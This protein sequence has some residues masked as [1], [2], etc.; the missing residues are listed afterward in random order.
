MRSIY[1]WIIGG[2]LTPEDN[3]HEW[4]RIKLFINISVTLVVIGSLVSIAALILGTHAILVPGMGNAVLATI[5]I[6]LLKF[7]KI[8]AAEIFYFSSLFILLFGNLIFNE[9]TMH[10]GSPFWVM[11]LNI[12]VTYIM[13]LR[14]GIV[15][16]IMSAFGFSYY[17]V[18]V[19]PHTLEIVNQLPAATYYS[20]IHETLIALFLL[21][22]VLYII[23]STS[24][25]SDEILKQKNTALTE[26][27][28][29]IVKNDEEKTV[30]LKEIHHRVKNNLQVIISLMRLQMSNQTEEENKKYQEMIN[31]VLTMAL[32]HEKIYQSEDLSQIMLK[33]YF[34]DLT[35]D[36]LHSYQVDTNVELD[37]RIDVDKVGMKSLVPIALI[38]NELFSN[39]LKHAFDGMSEGRVHFQLFSIDENHIGMSYSD[40]GNWKEPSRTSSLG[41]ELVASL[42]NQLDGYMEFTSDPS[43]RYSFELEVE[44]LA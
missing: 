17:M 21:G 33:Q 10:A 12:L 34:N 25:R 26:R 29:I 20:V 4:S 18:E 37:L 24:K 35:E 11:L 36:I 31:R 2:Q 22:Y 8:K 1:H 40:S 3:L 19:Y 43:T 38:F 42:T 13:G 28:R 15:F 27:N 9:G 44:N 30:M 6:A 14:W 39:S 23:L 5:A 32:I 16:M 41:L 7:G